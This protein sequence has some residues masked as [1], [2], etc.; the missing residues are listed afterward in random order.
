MFQ[1][2]FYPKGVPQVRDY[3]TKRDYYK[4]LEVYA[5]YGFDEI[6][7]HHGNCQNSLRQ[8]ERLKEQ[9]VD[10]EKKL[11]LK[12]RTNFNQSKQIKGLLKCVD[13]IGVLAVKK[14]SKKS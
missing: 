4:A 7:R 9:I 1:V 8:I 6:V 3:K 11:D 13:V 10:L 5:E 14:Q 12:R 2:K